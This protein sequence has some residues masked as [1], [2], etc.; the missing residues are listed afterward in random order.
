[1][2]KMA[3]VPA[4]SPVFPRGHY[5]LLSYEATTAQ[6]PAVFIL[7]RGVMQL[8][9]FQIDRWRNS[10]LSREISYIIVLLDTQAYMDEFH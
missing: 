1:M 6:P 2:V 5:E 10:A 9:I 8:M 3:G 4:I 7:P